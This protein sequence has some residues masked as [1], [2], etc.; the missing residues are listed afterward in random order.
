VDVPHRDASYLAALAEK[1][2][3][4]VR[5]ERATFAAYLNAH[6]AGRELL[7]S[8][9]AHDDLA[10]RAT[11]LWLACGIAEGSDEAARFFD[12]RYIAPLERTLARMRLD[13]SMLDEVKQLVRE[14]LLVRD[15][16][17]ASA[18]IEEYAGRGRL[19]GLVQVVATREALTLL[20]RGAREVLAGDDDLAEPLVG[21]TD[22]GLEMLKAKYR[23]AFRAAFAGAVAALT[24]KQ[25]N[26]L[27][28]HLL[29][30]V[31][32]EQLA[33]VNGV[34]RATIVRWLKE[35]RDG[36][37]AA[38]EASLRLTLGVRADELESLLGL[39]R[40]RL[41]VSIERLLRTD[42]DAEPL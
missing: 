39:A 3:P 9:T 12:E 5:L 26:L 20:R 31:T 4:F 17:G 15:G 37:L 34:H 36:V 21:T 1:T 8:D 16:S 14:K 40:S 27:R 11:E 6:P 2:A 38:T 32:L 24:P 35:A 41:D 28:M 30:G 29:G 23:E 18:R 25:R 42:D 19:A 33:S 13:A 7:A 10:E 22:P